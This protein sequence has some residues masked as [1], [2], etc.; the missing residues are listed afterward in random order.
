MPIFSLNVYYVTVLLRFTPLLQ[1]DA[2]ALCLEKE[3][4]L[5]TSYVL[6]LLTLMARSEVLINNLCSHT[7][8]CLLLSLYQYLLVPPPPPP[9]PLS[10]PDSLKG[11]V[12]SMRGGKE[13]GETHEGSGGRED[14]VIQTQVRERE[15]KR[16]RKCVYMPVHACM[17]VPAVRI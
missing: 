16:E 3:D 17:R 13:V 2:I 11:V 14:C 1:K 7:E 10:L 9:P 5:L 4:S 6:T 12:G 8:P 15:R